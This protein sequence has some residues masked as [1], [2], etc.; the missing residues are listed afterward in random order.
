MGPCFRQ[1]R[2]STGDGNASAI[3]RSTQGWLIGADTH[4]TQIWRLG[5]AV[6][7]SRSSFE[8]QD[9][10]STGSSANHHVGLYAGTDG[11]AISLRSGLTYS[12][13]DIM[14]NRSVSIGDLAD[15]PQA[16]YGGRTWQ[17]FGE[18][19]YRIDSENATYEPFVGLAHVGLYTDGFAE[20]GEAAALTSSG[21]LSRTTLAML[22][23]R[24]SSVVNLSNTHTPA[25]LN[26]KIGW[27]HAFGATRPRSTHAFAGGNEFTVKG[28]PISAG[29][30]L[31]EFGLDLD[32]S[33]NTTL[34]LS[35]TGQLASVG[36][37]HTLKG[38]IGVRF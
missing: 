30:A 20:R 2:I 12:W 38:T 17:A 6:G 35:Y 8:V 26:G 34:S 25:K 11:R 36:R 32:L 23:V 3:T 9:R 10:A 27:S 14:T 1:T 18:L 7:S 15:R 22:G 5:W 37:D 31:V 33:S 19:G 29:T 4:S 16:N 24:L 21:Q 28:V 13:H